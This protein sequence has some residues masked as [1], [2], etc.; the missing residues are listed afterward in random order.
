MVTIVAPKLNT[1]VGSPVERFTRMMF[2]RIMT[3]LARTLRDEE[4]S[5]AQLAAIALVDQAGT[6]RVTE[7]ADSLSLSPS[8]ASR[9][10]DG[11][12]E[13][14]LLSRSEDPDDRRARRVTLAPAGK[15]FADRASRDR[16]A[17]IYDTIIRKVPASAVNVVLTVAKSIVG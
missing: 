3:N 7:L 5:V 17:L 1:A 16:V 4:M 9:L 11:L 14:R 13:R 15:A 6:V 10:I 8:A 2:N 12:V